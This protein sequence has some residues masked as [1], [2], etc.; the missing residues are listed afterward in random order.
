MCVG[1]SAAG[2]V[3]AV[4]PDVRDVYDDAFS[5]YHRSTTYLPESCAEE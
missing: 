1:T 3:Q 5:M 4:S 2:G